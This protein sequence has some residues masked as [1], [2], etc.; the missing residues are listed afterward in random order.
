MALR[1]WVSRIGIGIALLVVVALLVG[2]LLGQPVL[3]G[4]VTSGSMAPTLSA[5]D[6]FVAIPAAVAGS[7]ED[8]DVVTYR[9]QEIQGGG[10]TTH[11]VVSETDRGF[12]TRGDANP[13]T[14]QDA[15]EPPVK[16]VQIVAVAWQPGGDVLTVPWV[17][18][19]VEGV[20][21]LLESVQQRFAILL[22]SRSML[23]TQGLAYLLLGASLFGYLADVLLSGDRKRERE[24]SR[25]DG[26]DARLY[27]GLFAAALVV[28]TTAA[29]AVPAGPQAIGVVSAE[30]DG[31]GIDVVE[32]GTTE[33]ARYRLGNGGFVPMITYLDPVTE[34]VNVQPRETVIPGQSTVNATLTITAPPETGYYRYYV[35][36]HRYL[37]LLPRTV[38]DGL[39]RIHPWAPI[40]AIDLLVG[41]TFYLLGRRIV[42]RGRVRSHSRDGPSRIKLLLAKLLP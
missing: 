6:G 29:M 12:V 20:N 17:G 5:G 3:L 28:S 36:E 26:L 41:G 14:D 11:R 30:S 15:G 27:V 13:F 1:R 35:T 21:S 4:Y 24:R 31:P 25:S 34:G 33:S 16:D 2:Q 18:A 10:L 8:G 37:H 7:V 9:A 42:G 19:V 22:G 32:Q 23:G 38:I 40:V 39:Y